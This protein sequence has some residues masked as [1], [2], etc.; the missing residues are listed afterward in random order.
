MDLI[1]DLTQKA[2]DGK[3]LVIDSTAESMKVVP[4]SLKEKAK[5]LGDEKI[6]D[7]SEALETKFNFEK[8]SENNN[9]CGGHCSCSCN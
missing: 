3:D 7:I 2:K 4:D 8:E 1:D 5:D 9:E 6:D